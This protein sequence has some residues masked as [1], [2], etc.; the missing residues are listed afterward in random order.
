[1]EQLPD[2]LLCELVFGRLFVY[3]VAVETGIEAMLRQT[4]RVCRES[5]LESNER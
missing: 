4:V 1:M 5:A 3:L 2:A